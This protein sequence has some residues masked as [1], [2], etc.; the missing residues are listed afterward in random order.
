MALAHYILGLTFVFV[1]IISIAHNIVLS[2]LWVFCL[3]ITFYKAAKLVHKYEIFFTD[4][5]VCHNR[6]INVIMTDRNDSKNQRT[7]DKKLKDQK[8]QSE[9]NQNY[10]L[11]CSLCIC[12]FQHLID[13]H[14]VHHFM[15]VCFPMAIF[16]TSCASFNILV[17]KI[18][19]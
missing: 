15:A 14:H 5:T 6:A 10:P 19:T 7:D 17:T 4:V 2:I 8:T 18:E 13:T 3:I 11:N 9:M 12:L 16:S 1:A